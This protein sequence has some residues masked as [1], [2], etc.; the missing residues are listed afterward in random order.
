[1]KIIN[2]YTTFVP[3]LSFV[4]LFLGLAPHAFAAT[5]TWTGAGADN[6]MTDA[7]NWGGSAPVAGDDLVFPV[8]TSPGGADNDFP[9][10]TVFHS[11]TFSGNTNTDFNTFDFW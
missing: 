9:A 2:K 8:S 11:I 6:S 5:R 3:L 10:G 1:M 7:G 4:I